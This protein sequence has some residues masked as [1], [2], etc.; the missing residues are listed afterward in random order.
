MAD[1]ETPMMVGRIMIP[2]RIDAVSMLFPLPPKS[3]DTTRHDNDHTEEAI[4]NRWNTCQQ[5][6][7]RFT[8]LYTGFGQNL[9]INTAVRIP[10]GTPIED[11]ARSY[12]NAA[13]D[14]RQ[15]TEDI[16]ARL[17][18]FTGQK[19]EYANLSDGRN[20][21]CE[22]KT[23]IMATHRMDTQALSRN[24]ICISCSFRFFMILT[25]FL[26]PGEEITSYPACFT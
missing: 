16:V 26:L 18:L 11:R 21:V 24:T 23:Q 12:I 25:F 6:D 8:T 20:S 22:R 17:P 2:S 10:I 3:W 9:D 4:Y 15:N 14:H 5:I 19:L 7:R 13:E 1:S